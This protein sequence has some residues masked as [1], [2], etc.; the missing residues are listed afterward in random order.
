[1]NKLFLIKSLNNH[2]DIEGE[3]SSFV[4]FLGDSTV[5]GSSVGGRLSTFF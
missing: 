1:M 3:E 4:L 2:I 5:G